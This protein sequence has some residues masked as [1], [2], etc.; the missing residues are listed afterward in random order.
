MV[1][2]EYSWGSGRLRL[3]LPERTKGREIKNKRIAILAAVAALMLVFVAAV[4]AAD[5]S[6]P[7]VAMK[8]TPG[9]PVRNFN[10]NIEAARRYNIA[11]VVKSSPFRSGSRT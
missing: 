4:S 9:P 5:A 7:A 2:T 11:I 10:P 8:G 1:G 6:K 3:R